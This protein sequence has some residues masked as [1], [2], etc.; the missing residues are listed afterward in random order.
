MEYGIMRNAWR[1]I[2]AAKNS[3]K[4]FL[5]HAPIDGHN[6]STFPA[7]IGP[8]FT[9]WPMVLWKLAGA[10]AESVARSSFRG[11]HPAA[12]SDAG[13]ITARKAKIRT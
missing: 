13:R 4:L 1:C 2:A 7:S 8:R 5:L 12:R 9:G 3:Q 6:I 10:D 11:M